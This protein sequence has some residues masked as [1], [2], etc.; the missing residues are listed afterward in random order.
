MNSRHL[1]QQGMDSPIPRL[2]PPFSQPTDKCWP[3][4][5][6]RSDSRHR[7]RHERVSYELH[8][9]TVNFAAA[10]DSAP[11]CLRKVKIIPP[12]ENGSA[13]PLAGAPESSIRETTRPRCRPPILHYSYRTSLALTQGTCFPAQIAFSESFILL[14]LLRSAG[15]VHPHQ[16]RPTPAGIPY[17]SCFRPIGYTPRPLPPGSPPE[18][19]VAS[20]L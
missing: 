9:G 5:P 20:H 13:L 8:G 7:I 12:P 18:S 17:S 3:C 11:F 6:T 10:A 2:C 14:F 15:G 1:R 16:K 4:F 19:R